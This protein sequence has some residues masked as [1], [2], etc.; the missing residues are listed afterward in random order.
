MPEKLSWTLDMTAGPIYVQI[1]RNVRRFL[2][3]GDLSPGGKLPSARE[4][5]QTLGVNPNT[6]VRAFSYLQEQKIIFNK[7]GIGYF[8]TED[9][10]SMAQQLKRTEFIRKDLPHFFRG[11]SMLDI[12]FEEIEREYRNYSDM[13]EKR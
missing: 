7:R 12:S 11:I 6:V 3:R 13:E 10:R 2:A 8:V 5:A 1:G 4:L 9:G